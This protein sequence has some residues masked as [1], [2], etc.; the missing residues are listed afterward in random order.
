[1]KTFISKSLFSF[2]TFLISSYVPSEL[3]PSTNIISRSSQNFGILLIIKLIFPFSFLQGTITEIGGLEL[4]I[5]GGLKAGI[6]TFIY[7][8]DNKGDAKNTL[9]AAKELQSLGISIIIG[10]IFHK[11]SHL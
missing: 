8:K 3:P 6:K 9:S 1:M 4:K 2:L 5:M 11:N 7:P 10:P